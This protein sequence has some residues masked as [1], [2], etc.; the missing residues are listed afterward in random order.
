MTT[1]WIGNPVGGCL[2][3]VLV[4][5]LLVGGGG[6]PGGT[7]GCGGAWSCGGGPSLVRGSRLGAW[8]GRDWL[9]RVCGVGVADT[10][11]RVTFINQRSG[12][13]GPEVI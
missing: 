13:A 4:R 8:W 10:C 6:V 12:V 3:L 9:P 7:W 2:G 5:S 1:D 11:S